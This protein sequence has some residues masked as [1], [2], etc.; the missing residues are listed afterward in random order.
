MPDVIIVGAGAAGL[1][2]ARE[3]R[4]AGKSFVILES[5]NRIGGRV[6]TLNETLA[7]VPVELGAEFIHG[8]APA[9]RKLLDQ[10]RLATVAVSGEHYRSDQGELS[11]QGPIWQRMARVFRHMNADRKTDRSFQDFLDDKPGGRSLA[12]E[13]DLARGFVEGFNGA[14]SRLISEKSL[15]QQGNPTESAAEAARVVNG[16]QALIGFMSRDLTGTVKTGDRVTRV[17][18]RSDGVTVATEKGSKY[19]SQAVILTVPLPMLQDDSIVIEPELPLLRSSARLLV[20]GHVARIAVVVKERFWE[21][22]L[23]NVS[24]VHTP[25]R[26][27]NV[28]WTQNPISAPVLIAWAGGPS[29]LELMTGGTVDEVVISEMSRVFGIARKRADS[30]VESLHY[31]LWST[32]PNTLGAYSYAGVGGAFAARALARSFENRI[33]LAGEATES[34]TTG[35]V[36]GALIS[37]KRAAEKLMQRLRS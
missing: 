13:R 19:E 22:K 14:D 8:D 9:T 5:S 36:E 11:P 1:M 30:L 32:D 15:A 26:R 4:A 16:Y 12:R 37:G 6:M 2:A 25:E 20:M 17:E 18:W 28:W 31:H 29:A 27:F 24:F 7:G 34:A 10:A 23:E 33:Y 21:R 35:T 3:L